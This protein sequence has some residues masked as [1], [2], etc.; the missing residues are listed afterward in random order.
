MIKA[1]EQIRGQNFGRREGRR[2]LAALG[3]KGTGGQKG[4]RRGEAGTEIRKRFA[5]TP[6]FQASDPTDA[7]PLLR[8]RRNYMRNHGVGGCFNERSQFRRF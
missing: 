2:G 7:G 1:L 8:Q 4:K 5:H 6:R 3:S